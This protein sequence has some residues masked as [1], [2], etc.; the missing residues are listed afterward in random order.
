MFK[1]IF[2]LISLV[3]ILVGSTA[4]LCIQI[5]TNYVDIV[6]NSYFKSRVVKNVCV[7]S[8]VFYEVQLFLSI[9]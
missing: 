5:C 8:N 9:E 6:S 1:K 7:K 3:G 2:N 4:T